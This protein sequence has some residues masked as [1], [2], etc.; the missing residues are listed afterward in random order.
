VI[1]AYLSPAKSKEQMIFLR[2]YIAAVKLHLGST[3]HSDQTC[4]HSM[5]TP[6]IKDSTSVF[7]KFL[8]TLKNADL[9][10]YNRKISGVGVKV[11]V[12]FDLG[13]GRIELQ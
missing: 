10:A 2:I 4:I 6:P 7:E 3:Q 13:L 1:C 11:T 9:P 8:T 5:S 12:F